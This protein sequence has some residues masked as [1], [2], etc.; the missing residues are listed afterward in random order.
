MN[1][2]KTAY[3]VTGYFFQKVRFDWDFGR[4]DFQSG[5]GMEKGSVEDLNEAKEVFD[6]LKSDVDIISVQIEEYIETFDQ[7]GSFSE[8]T[9]VKNV[10]EFKK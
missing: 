7:E 1:T 3:R 5:G 2:T 9:F 6:N 8:E 4:H 10:D